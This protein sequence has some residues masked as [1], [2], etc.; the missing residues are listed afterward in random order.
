[1]PE[2][3]SYQKLAHCTLPGFGNFWNKNTMF[4]KQFD[5][6]WRRCKSTWYCFSGFGKHHHAHGEAVGVYGLQVLDHPTAFHAEF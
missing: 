3:P 5:I 6:Q 2:S 1:M 4:G